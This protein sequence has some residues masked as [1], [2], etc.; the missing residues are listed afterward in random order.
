MCKLKIFFFIAL[1]WFLGLGEVRG[2]DWVSFT[3]EPEGPPEVTVLESDG[4]HTIVEV[5]TPGMYVEEIEVDGEIF[6]FITLP[7]VF[8]D[9]EIGKPQITGLGELIAVPGM[10]D[11][12][13]NVLEIETTNLDGYWVYPAQPPPTTPEPDP[14]FEI[15][16]EFYQIDSYYPENNVELGGAAIWRDLRVVNPAVYPIRF[17][18]SEQRLEVAYYI[19]FELTYAGTSDDNVKDDPDYPIEKKYADGYR[20]IILN[21]D[22]L[23]LPETGLDQ[24]DLDYLIITEG[25][26][27]S[28]L[29][30]LVT[31]LKHKRYT[32]KI[33]KT[34]DPGVG[35]T[36]QSIKEYIKNT[37][38][39]KKTKY[40]LLVGDIMKVPTTYLAARYQRGEKEIM[41]D[42]WYV[43]VSGDDIIPDLAIGRLSVMETEDLAHQVEK[44]LNYEK[45]ATGG[46]WV[47]KAVLVAHWERRPKHNYAYDFTENKERIRYDGQL[48]EPPLFDV[49]YGAFGAKNEHVTA[50]INAGRG[51]VNYNGHGGDAFWDHW[52]AEQNSWTTNN[53][54]T[55]RHDGRTPVIFSMGCYNSK[56]DSEN[57]TISERWLRAYWPVTGYGAVA[58]V[59]ASRK[60]YS[61]VDD[62]FDRALFRAIFRWR[63]FEI[64]D[65]VN[66]AKGDLIKSTKVYSKIPGY[67]DIA[68][69]IV[70][71]YLTLGEPSM[72]IRTK[73]SR[74]FVIDCRESV[75]IGF[76]VVEVEVFNEDAVT[77]VENAVVCLY[78]EDDVHEAYTTDGDG[79]VSFD[80]ETDSSGEITVTVTKHGY[81]PYQVTIDVTAE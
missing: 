48:L 21:Y 81:I 51:I 38:Q 56:L 66:H 41:S 80:I 33:A 36:W 74:N 67:K 53:I 29:E 19:K 9:G 65:V 70:L 17:N 23:G 14:G 77:P 78:K 8:F 49:L 71:E 34:T 28:T 50:A 63:V 12:G 10:K 43:C 6:H 69:D 62:Y 52:D 40:L 45:C 75:P 30:P 20:A 7:D 1:L 26:F 47:T 4:D 64:G 44:I 54:N 16:R 76:S 35:Q 27:F 3:G 37:Y 79:L 60:S 24:G 32:V 22:W 13:V 59:G 18:P 57:V 46:N 39:N 5:S 58:A 2:A 25:M 31:W 73:V 55:L 11:I 15:D 72:D 68:A 42:H 61:G